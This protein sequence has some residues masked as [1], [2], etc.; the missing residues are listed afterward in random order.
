[1]PPVPL[2]LALIGLV[3]N[4]AVAATLFERGDM[5]LFP[6]FLA[7]TLISYATCLNAGPTAVRTAEKE[8]P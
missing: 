8:T 4:V 5:Q 7:T 6:L 2:W 3:G 1:M